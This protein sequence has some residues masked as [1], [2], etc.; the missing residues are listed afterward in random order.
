MDQQEQNYTSV[1]AQ[2]RTNTKDL[3]RIPSNFIDKRNVDI[4]TF[5]D[6]LVSLFN[7]LGMLAT[8]EGDFKTKFQF[9][10]AYPDLIYPQNNV[11]TYEVVSRKPFTS[12]SKSVTGVSN[13]YLKPMYIEEKY[14]KI[15]GNMEQIY[16]SIFENIISINCFSTKSSILNDMC[17]LLESVMIKY[18]SYLKR[19]IDEIVY[20]GQGSIQFI[21]SNDDKRLFSK[22]LQFKIITS[23][24]FILESEQLKEIQ[25][26][27]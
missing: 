26:L 13:T 15:T 11:M 22:Q 21:D 24:M 6:A 14:N 1:F 25:F 5:Y 17:R 12:V 4:F 19:Y 3:E 8:S 10:N 27:V 2:L 18:S 20:L 9:I 16:T 23:E 7:Q